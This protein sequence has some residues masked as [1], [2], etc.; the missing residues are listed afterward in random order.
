[1]RL[2]IPHMVLNKRLTLATFEVWHPALKRAVE[3]LY[4]WKERQRLEPYA[5]L[6]ISGPPHTGKTHLAGIVY[7]SVR[8]K[9]ESGE[10]GVES[11]K[12]AVGSGQL[13][14]TLSTTGGGEEPSGVFY[15]AQELLPNLVPGYAAREIGGKWPVVVDDVGTEQL[16][17][18]PTVLW[19][20]AREQLRERFRTVSQVE[21]RRWAVESTTMQ[22]GVENAR[23][24]RYRRL[25]EHCFVYQLPVVMVTQ[26]PIHDREG[27][28]VDWI[29]YGAWKILCRMAPPESVID[30]AGMPPY[31]G[32]T[33]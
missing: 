33:G 3:Q 25:M 14:G 28:F 12:L 23:H 20:K 22:K 8:R 4:A 30:L 27:D 29:G 26:L 18:A 15:T 31:Q 9:V 19:P 32:S 2:L 13:T 1:M 24:R 11:G 17:P 5:S 10:W 21:R 6:I 16:D 7:W